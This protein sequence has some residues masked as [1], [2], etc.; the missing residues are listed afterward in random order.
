[1]SSFRPITESYP[2]ISCVRVNVVSLIVV[3]I[4]P[5][6]CYCFC[7]YLE[8]QNVP[9]TMYSDAPLSSSPGF[10][11]R[12]SLKSVCSL[13]GDKSTEMGKSVKFFQVLL[14]NYN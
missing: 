3:H 13:T 11:T 10:V 7:L 9:K 2:L 5:V 1:M 4:V 12:L 8:T 14:K 6:S